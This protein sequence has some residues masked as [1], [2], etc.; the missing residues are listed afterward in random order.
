MDAGNENGGTALIYAAIRGSVE[1]VQVLLQHG[2][3]V[4]A[5]DRDSK[6]ALTY[7]VERGH[8]DIARLITGSRGMRN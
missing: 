3:D 5:R 6:T 2:A 8:Q 7:A 1:V 4:N